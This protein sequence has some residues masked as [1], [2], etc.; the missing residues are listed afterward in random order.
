V[1][2]FIGHS[3]FD[4]VFRRGWHNEGMSE[5]NNERKPFPLMPA[6]LTAA[7]LLLLAYP[8][9][10]FWLGTKQ[11]IWASDLVQM[12]A[13]VVRLYPHKWQVTV[14]QP[15]AYVESLCL[16]VEVALGD[17]GTYGPTDEEE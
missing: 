7:L 5:R 6:V 16:G 10:Y 11:D 8:T 15:A 17:L 12:K 13:G 4:C 2:L 14:F 1:V 3:S 9:C